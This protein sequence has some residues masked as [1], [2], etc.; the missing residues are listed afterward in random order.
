MLHHQA[1]EEPLHA[2]LLG[3]A[4]AQLAIG[5]CACPCAGDVP[6]LF[7]PDDMEA[8]SAGVRPAMAAAGLPINKM[9]IYSYFINRCEATLCFCAISCACRVQQC[10]RCERALT[11]DEIHLCDGLCW[12]I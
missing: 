9:T 7:G 10:V 2:S 1:H 6:N 5:T 8:I 3:N 11:V 12:W 4:D